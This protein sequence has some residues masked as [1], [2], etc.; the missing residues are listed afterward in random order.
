MFVDGIR[1]AVREAGL[2]VELFDAHNAYLS[3]FV[4]GY[5][6]SFMRA[7]DHAISFEEPSEYQKYLSSYVMTAVADYTKAATARMNEFCGSAARDPLGQV[8]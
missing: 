6:V 7:D 8:D 5:P 1:G 4:H 2:S 3:Q